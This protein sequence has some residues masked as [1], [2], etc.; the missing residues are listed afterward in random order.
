[1]KV[2]TVT[3]GCFRV[4]GQ[5]VVLPIQGN[6][7]PSDLIAWV[8]SRHYWGRASGGHTGLQQAWSR[9]QRLHSV[10]RTSWNSAGHEPHPRTYPRSVPSKAAVD[11]PSIPGSNSSPTTS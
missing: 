3:D 5:E 10:Q 7:I 8:R 9:H 4:E 1:M 2:L 11:P 6:L